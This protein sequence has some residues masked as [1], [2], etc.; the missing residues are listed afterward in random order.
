[1]FTDN[2]LNDLVAALA[3]YW[4]AVHTQDLPVNAIGRPSRVPFG[5]SPSENAAD[6]AR[7]AR[8]GDRCG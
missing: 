4:N 8:R 1:M 6:H 3:T 2:S 7:T 5:M